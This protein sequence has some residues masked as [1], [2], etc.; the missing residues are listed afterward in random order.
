MILVLVAAE[1]NI[2]TAVEGT[3]D[4]GRRCGHFL[5]LLSGLKNYCCYPAAKSQSLRS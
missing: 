5:I 4:G 3:S 1:R 2:K